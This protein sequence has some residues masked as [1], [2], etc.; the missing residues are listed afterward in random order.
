M[1]HCTKALFAILFSLFIKVAAY[2]QVP[3]VPIGVP[4]GTGIGVGIKLTATYPLPYANLAADYRSVYLYRASEFGFVEGGTESKGIFGIG[5]DVA[6]AQGSPLRKFTIRFKEVD[7]NVMPSDPDMSGATV[8][9]YTPTYVEGP[10]VNWHN[11]ADAYCWDGT[12]N[13]AVE[14]CVTNPAEDFS[15]NAKVAVAPPFGLEMAS[16]HEWNNSGNS[17]CDDPGSGNGMLYLDRPIA[18]FRILPGS[19]TDI[20]VVSSISPEEV[21]DSEQSY[22]IDFTVQN[23]SC[24]IVDTLVLEYQWM[25]SAVVSDTVFN[26]NLEPGHYYTHQF[27]QPLLA[28][29]VGFNDFKLWINN[30][31]DLNHSNDTL[32]K[33]IWV[34][35]SDFTGLDFNGKEF[36]GAFMANYNNGATLKQYLYITSPNGANVTVSFPL[37]GW[38]KSFYVA[39]KDLYSLEIPLHIAQELIANDTSE[40]IKPTSYFVKADEAISVYGMSTQYQSTDAFLAIPKRSLGFE[41]KVISPEGTFLPGAAASGGLYTDAPSEFVVVATEDNTKVKIVAPV[42]TMMHE[43]GDTIRVTLNEGENFLVK[44]RVDY[45]AGLSTKTYEL[46]GAHVLSDK[47]VGVISGAQCAMIP[48]QSKLGCQACDHLLE[49]T[50]P[51]STLGTR[52]VTVDFEYKPGNDYLQIFN[53]NSDSIQVNISGDVNQSFYV[54]ANKYKDV[55]FQGGMVVETSQ[56]AIVA[57]MCT[58]GQCLPISMT[59]PF[60]TNVISENQW[61]NVFSYAAT[62]GFNIGVHYITILKRSKEGRIAIDGNK[63][64]A[65]NFTQ[66]PGSEYYYARLRSSPGKHRVTGDSLFV[67]YAYGF[68][69]DDSYGYPASGALLIPADVPEI[70]G[71]ATALPSKCFN[72]STGTAWVEIAGGTA[73]FTI[74]W[75]N[76]EHTDTIYNLAPGRYIVQVIDDFGMSF[77][78]TVW[79]Q[80]PDTLTFTK[81]VVDVAC[82]GDE[83]GSIMYNPMGGVAPYEVWSAGIQKNPLIELAE[84][85]HHATIVD[86]NGCE[87]IDST[88]IQ[89]NE[90]LE[91]QGVTDM[92]DCYNGSNGTLSLSA[93]GGVEDYIFYINGGVASSA[94][95]LGPGNQNARVID[96]VGCQTDSIFMIDNPEEIRVII[97]KKPVGC[98][99]DSLGSFTVT[100]TGGRAPLKYIFQGDTTNVSAFENL[101]AGTYLVSVTDGYCTK[102]SRFLIESI[103][104]PLFEVQTVEDRCAA[105]NG[106]ASVLASLG[107]GSYQYS[108]DDEPLTNDNVK[109]NLSTG[110]HKLVGTDGVCIDTLLFYIDAIPSPDFFTSTSAETCNGDNGTIHFDPTRFWKGYEWFVDD[111]I[112]DGNASLPLDSGWHKVSILDSACTVTKDVYVGIVPTFIIDN[113]DKK[114]PTCNASNGEIRV[115]VSNGASTT[116]IKWLGRG[117]TSF[118]LTGLSQGVYTAVVSDNLCSDTLSIAL[119]NVDGPQISIQHFDAHCELDNGE[120]QVNATGGTGQYS[121]RWEDFPTNTT[122]KASGLSAGTYRVFVS[123][124]VC[125]NS[126]DVPIIDVPKLNINFTTSNEHCDLADGELSLSFTKEIGTVEYS[127]NGAVPTEYTQPIQLKE[128]SYNL[129][130]LDDYCVIDT[131]FTIGKFPLPTLHY[132]VQDEHCTSG[133]A[134]IN[135]TGS[136][137]NGSLNYFFGDTNTPSSSAINNLTAG[138]YFIAVSDGFCY[139]SAIVGIINYPSPQAFVSSNPDHCGKGVGTA[140]LDSVKGTGATNFQMN[141]EVYEVGDQING[142]TNGSHNWIITDSLCSTNGAISI[143]NI[144]PPIIVA[145]SIKDLSCGQSNGLIHLSATGSE[146]TYSILWDDGNTQWQRN[147]LSEGVYTATISGA[148]CTATESFAIN[149]LPVFGGSVNELHPAYCQGQKGALSVAY[150]NQRGD[151][152]LDINGQQFVN[153]TEVKFLPAGTYAYTLSDDYCSVSGS[154]NIDVGPDLDLTLVSTVNDTCDNATGEVVS[155]LSNSFGTV[156]YKLNGAVVSLPIKNLAKGVYRL[157]VEDDF[158]SDYIDFIID[159]LDP[160]NGILIVD[161]LDACEKSIGIARYSSAD[162]NLKYAWDN[163]VGD[164][165]KSNLAEGGHVLIVQNDFCSDTIPFDLGAYPNF[166]LDVQTFNDFCD[167]GQGQINIDVNGNTAPYMVNAYGSDWSTPYTDSLLSRGEYVYAVTDTFGCTQSITEQIINVNKALENGYIYTQPGEII[168]GDSVQLAFWLEEGWNFDHWVINGETNTTEN[169]LIAFDKLNDV[170]LVELHVVHNNFCTDVLTVRISPTTDGIVFAPNAFTP[171]GDGHNDS[172]FLSGVN[173]KSVE[174]SIYNRWGEEIIKFTGPADTWDGMYKGKLVQIDVYNYRFM[175]EFESGFKK[176]VFGSVR[177]VR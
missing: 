175:V 101:E 72:D 18:Y 52:F 119:N 79:V 174:G 33:L 171:N 10:G 160:P 43:A 155:Q 17:V 29:P 39:S 60:Y 21:L 48:S 63:L 116:Y 112:Q 16:W 153:P 147:N 66:I 25:D 92:P 166:V 84:G 120:I 2:G 99:R 4:V 83:T 150:Q 77:K 80:S 76:D 98:Y 168:V 104:S 11:F 75:S 58:G 35:D 118:V 5:W 121:Y 91:L 117:E 141:S 109:T 45:V 151:V 61:A 85:W 82:N 26:L 78:D 107:T 37:L 54:E 102:T 9:Y 42:P 53:P 65:S 15:L 129:K 94:S 108:W 126:V 130:V 3:G 176:Q 89:E 149:V 103:S 86:A 167:L 40:V 132:S 105:N 156:V 49:Q 1:P 139:D 96:A 145:D 71:F 133:N 127:I 177:V 124:D 6:S 7:W 44:G 56:P 154:V 106:E 50:P 57:Q 32:H 172:F 137:Y 125:E 51:V 30:A 122:S 46:T 157:E 24:N 67:T 161:Q 47:R 100:A 88:Y 142:L 28:N 136:S 159:G 14:V 134:S 138:S 163:V 41:Y 31:N 38:T 123:D 158:C 64:H 22:P 148:H 90:P 143:G 27:Q 81:T 68:G 62:A 115:E 36:W 114:A 169:P 23:L 146:S 87:V 12:K 152:K 73:P 13:L 170:A 111:K 173:I 74:N 135:L 93:I 8:V 144:V 110:T 97:D 55:A 70:E 131:I 34:K 59:D 162:E 165:I 20:G 19:K 140:V 164:S 95:N 128:G 69:Y 113:I